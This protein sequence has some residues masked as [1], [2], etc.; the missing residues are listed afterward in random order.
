MHTQEEGHEVMGAPYAAVQRWHTYAHSAVHTRSH[1]SD[2][3]E[4]AMP[5]ST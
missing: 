2:A 1:T 4:G 5:V 3:G